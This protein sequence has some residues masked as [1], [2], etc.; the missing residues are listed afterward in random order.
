[1]YALQEPA[2]VL[3]IDRR[4]DAMAEIR[5]PAS[6]TNTEGFTHLLHG[7]LNRVAS[8]I[9]D[10]GIHVTLERLVGA[11][12]T[13]SLNGIDAPVQSQDIVLGLFGQ[14]GESVVGAFSEEGYGYERDVF[15]GKAFAGFGGDVLERGEGELV[16]VIGRKLACPGVEYLKKLDGR[17]RGQ[18][19]HFISTL[20]K[21]KEVDAGLE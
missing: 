18:S 13:T 16:K 20:P 5:D 4:G 11:D 8:T 2:Q 21:R 12:E 10:I 14:F 17:M 1:M 19:F 7:P 6:T 9:K 3:W 15:F